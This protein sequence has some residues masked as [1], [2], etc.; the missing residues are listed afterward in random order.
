MLSRADR[1]KYARVWARWWHQRN[2]E[3]KDDNE[4]D[5]DFMAFAN[6]IRTWTFTNTILEEDVLSGKED[7]IVKIGQELCSHRL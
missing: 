3:C 2:N 6:C 4:A 5:K 7:Y 1:K